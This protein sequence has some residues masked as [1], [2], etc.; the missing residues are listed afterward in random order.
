[1]FSIFIMKFIGIDFSD[2]I[3]QRRNCA[4]VRRF[5]GSTVRAS[6]GCSL[7]SCASEAKQSSQSSKLPLFYA[8]RSMLPLTPHSL[9][10]ALSFRFSEQR[11]FV[12]CLHYSLSV[13]RSTLFSLPFTLYPL[14]FTLCPELCALSLT[15]LRFTLYALR[16]SLAPLS[17]GQPNRRRFPTDLKAFHTRG[18]EKVQAHSQK[19]GI[20]IDFL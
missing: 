16:Y 14:P 8:L 18:K 11:H 13:L 5:D 19:P 3:V 12:P 20:I 7:L 2:P 9:L 15:A 10:P 4:T 1:M 17:T 6:S